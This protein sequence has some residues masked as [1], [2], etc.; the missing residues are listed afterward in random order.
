MTAI[1][2]NH[3]MPLVSV[4]FPL[5]NEGEHI[6]EALASITN[7]TYNNIE[8]LISDN[9]STDNTA[10]ICQI[11]ANTNPRVLYINQ[12]VNIGASNNFFTLAQKATGK[13]LM[14]AA[15][16]DLWSENLIEK[17]VAILE[18]NESTVLAYGKTVWIDNNG[19]ET[20]TAS[21]LY[22]TKGLDF[23]AKF[24]I[25]MWSSMNPILGV[26]RK[27]AIPQLGDR[28]NFVGN[29]LV[30][31]LELITKGDFSCATEATFYRRHN[32]AAENHG[33]RLKRYKSDATK[34]AKS[35]IE[36]IVPLLRLPF[37]IIRAIIIS[38]LSFSEKIM[39]LLIT[40][41]ALPVKYLVG[42]RVVR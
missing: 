31:L 7:Q 16:H 17:C 28:Y 38:K 12:K 25:V 26:I 13:Y 20:L 22:D 8:I 30:L 35:P 32:R 33:E 11:I 41:P 42:K 39:L 40:I 4:C 15:G 34:L 24:A 21:G 37:M 5:Y 36:K 19:L 23:A 9:A 29:D 27:D 2:D 14:W 6:S 18:K 3:M 1:R 10:E